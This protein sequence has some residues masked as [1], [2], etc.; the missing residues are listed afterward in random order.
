MALVVLALLGNAVDRQ[1]GHEVAA[2]PAI[3]V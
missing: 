1:W 2:C 3:I